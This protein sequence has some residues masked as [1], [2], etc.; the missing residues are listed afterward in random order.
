L[1]ANRR[2]GAEEILS[3]TL[4]PVETPHQDRAVPES[5]ARYRDLIDDWAAF[6][7]AL[8]RPLP[9]CV[10]ENPLRAR[11][12]EL[13][14]A[15][16]REGRAPTPLAWSPGSFR[17]DDARG[18]G[19]RWWYL[20]GL[21][22]AQEEVSQV[23]VTLLDVRPGQRVLDLCAAPGGKTA[24]IAVALGNRGTVVANDVS[25]ARMRSLRDAV[26]RLGLV[27]VTVTMGDGG[28][29]TPAVGGFDRV[30]VDAPCSGE[31]TVRKMTDPSGVRF[32]EDVSRNYRGRQVALLRKAVQL[33]RPGGRI[34]YSTCTFAPE[35]N[36]AVVD[37]VLRQ[38]GGRGLALAAVAVPGLV[39]ASGA[40]RWHGET[41]DA[42]LSRAVRLWPHANDTGGFFVAVLDKH[43]DDP[44]P[45]G[46]PFAFAPV[47][48]GEWRPFVAERFGVPDD[49]FAGYR[50]HRRTLRGPHLVA[51]DHEAPGIAAVESVGIRFMKTKARYPK[52]TTP[53]ATVLGPHAT[54]NVVDL[55]DDQVEPY[56][57]RETFAARAG[58]AEACAG[59]GYV[60][61][62]HR[63]HVLGLALHR[64]GSAHLESAFPK[65]W[66]NDRP[67]PG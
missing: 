44:A 15:L 60:L 28:S 59:T 20:A 67:A 4:G 17:I 52:L 8:A 66:A 25:L 31:G 39:T 65:R 54:R 46:E 57:A 48:P 18:L 13:R 24:Q 43:G 2:A 58:Q 38:E 41:F 34:V 30:L 53:G 32:G 64:E 14:A 47:D 50:I 63:G 23:P 19:T 42:S 7:A 26:D 10:W 22:H 3:A 6:A 1:Y 29:L 36:E 61:V 35:E 11:P 51:R 33:C 21:A 56:L 49:V 5:F 9:T 55:T 12:D 37:T 27:N 40:T 16:E 45:A 62:R